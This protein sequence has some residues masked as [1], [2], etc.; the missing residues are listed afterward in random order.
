MSLGPSASLAVAV[1]VLPLLPGPAQGASQAAAEQLVQAHVA[2]GFDPRLRCPGLQQAAA[3]DGAVA[4]VVLRV[5]P[6]GVPSQ[7]SVKASS[8]SASFDA[9]VVE[10]ILKLRFLPVTRE[11]DGVP[12]DSWQQIAW[13]WVAPPEE[14]CDSPGTSVRRDGARQGSVVVD[15]ERERGGDHAPGRL[16]VQPGS[17]AVCVCIDGSGK[18]TREPAI[19]SSAGDAGIDKAAS[20]MAVAE[21]FRPAALEGGKP[22]P[23]CRLFRVRFERY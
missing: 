6:T 21:R 20:E 17:A 3:Q 18:L 16:A 1:L 23:G 5:G 8:G 4:A 19:A 22:V 2:Y 13:R 12:V 9:A 15:E 11:G 7:V 14:Q 10:C